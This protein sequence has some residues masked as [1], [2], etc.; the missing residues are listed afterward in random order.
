MREHGY[1]AL[2]PERD[3]PASGGVGL[4]TATHYE[5]TDGAV[6]LGATDA[7]IIRFSGVPDT[8]TLSAFV[9]DALVTLTD[10]LGR[11]GH[12]IRIPAG[13]PVEAPVQRRVVVAREVAAG[14]LLHVV[15]YWAPRGRPLEPNQPLPSAANP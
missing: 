3:A 5:G 6:T 8:I 14:A 1:P 9:Q 10:D 7:E 11:D 12:T 15:G 13:T 4:P 2:R